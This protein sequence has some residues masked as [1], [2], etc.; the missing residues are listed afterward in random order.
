MLIL[1]YLP[2]PYGS[3]PL[4]MVIMT[5]VSYI[6]ALLNAVN[7]HCVHPGKTLLFL[8][9]IMVRRLRCDVCWEFPFEAYLWC[10]KSI[11]NLAHFHRRPP[12]NSTKQGSVTRNTHIQNHWRCFLDSQTEKKKQS[13]SCMKANSDTHTHAGT[14]H[15]ETHISPK[16]NG[17][18]LFNAKLLGKRERAR[19]GDQRNSLWICGWHSQS[20]NSFEIQP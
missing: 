18:C 15:T 14:P 20:E 13:L 12:G 7:I 4:T 3:P 10:I 2:A 16:C 9:D 1:F 19:G 11:W 17:T 5:L 8:K 6:H